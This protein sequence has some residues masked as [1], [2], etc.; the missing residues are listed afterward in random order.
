MDNKNFEFAKALQGLNKDN[1][2]R[3]SDAIITIEPHIRDYV[4]TRDQLAEFVKFMDERIKL[5]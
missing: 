2:Q 3:Y 1:Y 4:A 5:R